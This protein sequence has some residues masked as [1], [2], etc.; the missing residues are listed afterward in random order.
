MTRVI[1]EC[2]VT[3]VVSS[4]QWG[5]TCEPKHDRRGQRYA[6]NLSDAE[7]ALIGPYLPQCKALGRP[8]E[9]DLRAVL[10]A[11]LYIARTGCQWRML[12]K[13]TPRR[14]LK[15]GFGSAPQ[16]ARFYSRQVLTGPSTED[17]HARQPASAFTEFYPV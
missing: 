15:P 10:D 7:W 3:L 12:P 17:I 5:T 13:P 16:A 8:R 6:S 1:S 11:I 4:K 9:T 14:P 2:C